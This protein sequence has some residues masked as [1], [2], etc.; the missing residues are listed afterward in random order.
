MNVDAARHYCLSF[1]QTTEKLQWGET[2]CFKVCGKIF[3]LLSLDSV[4]VT[5]CFKCNNERFGELTEIE[6]IIPAPYLGRYK[7]V[8][9]D[10]LDVLPDSELR[11]LIAESYAMVSAKAKVKRKPKKKKARKS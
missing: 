5:I 7:W 11:D 3:A 2:L 9:L 1:P 10:R 8:L 6:G 4:P